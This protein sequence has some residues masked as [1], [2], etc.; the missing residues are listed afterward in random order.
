LR[1][2]KTPGEIPVDIDL[3]L[4]SQSPSHIDLAIV[5]NKPRPVTAYKAKCYTFKSVKTKYFER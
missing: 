3:I 4:Y 1:W 2:T 5:V